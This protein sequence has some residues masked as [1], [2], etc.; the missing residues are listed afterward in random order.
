MRNEDWIEKPKKSTRKLKIEH[1]KPNGQAGDRTSGLEGKGEDQDPT[2]KDYEE[3]TK[4]QG[5]NT[6]ER[7]DST[8]SQTL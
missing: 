1:Y 5:R 2:S 4:P 3:L 6:Q 7:R 8:R